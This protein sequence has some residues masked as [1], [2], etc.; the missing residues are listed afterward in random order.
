MIAG[1]T[2]IAHT[3]VQSFQKIVFL[4]F[5]AIM[6]TLVFSNN[7]AAQTR[8]PYLRIARIVIDSPQLENYKAALK[9][10]MEAAVLIEPGVISLYAVYEKDHPTHV[11]VFETYADKNAYELHIQT[12]HFKKYKERVKDMVKSLELADV[13]TIANETKQQGNR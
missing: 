9:E 1:K 10:G 6:T 13:I 11:T 5:L 12:P 4:I 7:A 8:S 3:T 2:N